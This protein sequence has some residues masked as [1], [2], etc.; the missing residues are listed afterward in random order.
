MC[1]IVFNWQPGSPQWLTLSANRDEFFRRPARTLQEWDDVPGLFAGKDLEQGGTWLGMTRGGRWAALTNIRAPGAGPQEPL[2]RGQLVL[3]YLHSELSPEAWLEQ[4]DCSLYAPFNLLAG[5]PN[6]LWYQNN[7][8][9]PQ[10]IAVPAGIHS[11]SNAHLNSPWPKAQLA[12]QQLTELLTD[13]QANP[14]GMLS[15]RDIWPDSELPQTGVPLAW[16]RLLSAQ[17]I[18]APGYG[19]RCST[20]IQTDASGITISE[21]T[22]NSSGSADKEVSIHIGR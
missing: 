11:L 6:E 21:I 22:Y 7:H 9:T 4:L 1:L 10:R 2:S 19:T 15:H 17:F 12:K 8:P 3:D 5:T 20:G 14:A 16:E 13:M 18:Q